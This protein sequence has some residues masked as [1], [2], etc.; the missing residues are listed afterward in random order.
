M[1]SLKPIIAFA[2]SA[3][4]VAVFGADPQFGKECVTALS[5]GKEVKTDCSVNT[6]YEGKTYCFGN[7]EAKEI[8]LR[9]PKGTLAKATEN[10]DKMKK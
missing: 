4:A 9:D 10:Y 8:F 2:L 5:M 7:E 3:A 6:V 1:N